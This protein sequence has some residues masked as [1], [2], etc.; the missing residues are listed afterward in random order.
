MRLL[1]QSDAQ[2]FAG[3]GRHPSVQDAAILHKMD[4]LADRAAALL[5]VHAVMWLS[6]GLCNQQKI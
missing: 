3:W 5:Q 1:R 4:R 6:C 2:L